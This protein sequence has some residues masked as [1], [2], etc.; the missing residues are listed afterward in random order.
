MTAH[1]QSAIWAIDQVGDLDQRS[2]ARSAGNTA[3][4]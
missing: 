4:A 3:H 2:T 1:M